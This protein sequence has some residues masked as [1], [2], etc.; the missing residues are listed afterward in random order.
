MKKAFVHFAEGFEEI[1][2]LTIVDVL[3]RAGIPV[4]M[5]SVTGQLD[6][7]GAHEIT[8]KTDTLFENTD[9]EEAEIL[10]LPGGMP[11]SRNLNADEGL[12]KQLAYFSEKGKKIAAICAAPLV[13]GG[14]NILNG[15]EAVCY[16]GFENTLTGASLKYDPALKSG[17]IV[18][19]RG[20]GAAL[21][22]SLMLVEDLKGKN[23]ADQLARDM[24]VQTW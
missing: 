22:F 13:L 19:G 15:H 21:N 9:Y 16:P 11:G 24:L 4:L 23:E 5:I 1:E 8:V 6:V 2:A 10:I 17:N 3:R 20:P 18:T 14:L 7:T 12:K